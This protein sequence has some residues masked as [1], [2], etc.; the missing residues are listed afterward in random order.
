[1]NRH[2]GSDEEKHTG[3]DEEIHKVRDE[4]K[5]SSL[6]GI[7]R[8]CLHKHSANKWNN[9]DQNNSTP[10][11]STHHPAFLSLVPHTSILRCSSIWFDIS[12]FRENGHFSHVQTVCM[13]RSTDLQA[14]W[15]SS[16]PGSR[17]TTNHTHTRAHIHICTKTH[18]NICIRRHIRIRSHMRI[19][20][21]TKGTQAHDKSSIGSQ[22][23]NSPDT[24][25]KTTFLSFLFQDVLTVWIIH[26]TSP[27]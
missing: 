24:R 11:H 16:T 17:S 12:R 6:H 4:M 8:A 13:V 19:H 14:P 22:T 7:W 25:K 2:T 3:R 5:D 15:T 1:M 26:V 21:D 18:V 9:P 10:P 23:P 27:P 20:V